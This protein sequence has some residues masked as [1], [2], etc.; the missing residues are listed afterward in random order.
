MSESGKEG[1]S[2]QLIKKAVASGWEITSG[3]RLEIAGKKSSISKMED[4]CSCE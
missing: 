4:A 3:R 1:G 2:C